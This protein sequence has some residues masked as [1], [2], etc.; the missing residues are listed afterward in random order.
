[1][2][3]DN[4]RYLIN[5]LAQSSDWI[6]AQ[7]IAV[8]M[9]V[10]TRSVRNYIKEINELYDQ[11]PIIS[12]PQGYKW[13]VNDSFKTTNNSN[14]TIQIAQTPEERWWFIIRKIVFL[15]TT[16]PTKQ[17]SIYDICNTLV[18]S[19]AV[20]FRDVDEIRKQLSS[21]NISLHIKND[22]LFISGAELDIRHL[23][24]DT[25]LYYSPNDILYR[26]YIQSSF[27]QYK[28][29]DL[30]HVLNKTLDQ[31]D[32]KCDGFHLNHFM[33]YIV[34]QIIR[35][36]NNHYINASEINIPNLEKTPEY[37]GAKNLADEISSLNKFNYNW[38]EIDY[39]AMLF[40]GLCQNHGQLPIE[41]ESTKLEVSQCLMHLC[42]REN[43]SPFDDE[44]VKRITDYFEKVKIRTNFHVT[45]KNPLR[46]SIRAASAVTHDEAS[47]IVSY[48]RKKWDIKPNSDEISYLTMLLNSYLREKRSHSTII[49]TTLICPDYYEVADFI[50]QHLEIHFGGQIRITKTIRSF[51]LDEI[52][53]NDMYISVVTLNDCPNYVHISPILTSKDYAM[54]RHEINRIERSLQYKKF[55]MFLQSYSNN[56]L[57]EI[58]HH[59]TSS[60]DAIEY[61]C[62]KLEEKE[63]VDSTFVDI[64][65]EREDTESTSYFNFIAVPHATVSSV[66]RNA[67]YVILNQKPCN[68]GNRKVKLIVLFAMTHESV[69]DYQHFYRTIIQLFEDKNNM[70]AVMEAYNYDQF[71]SIIN[72]L[73]RSLTK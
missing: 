18:I 47:W 23:F 48:F 37:L 41:Y 17:I 10:T 40:L 43:I 62:Q 67:I 19:E 52:E 34:V 15:N 32:L 42:K 55:S 63:I 7:Q 20:F 35:I 68:W 50:K 57:F 72:K 3:K 24:Y 21:Y 29:D 12:S 65:K 25:L 51:D 16:S 8:Q 53:P 5:V 66:K 22:H 11:N 4:I 14:S 38:W 49:N 31:Y 9:N 36:S 56:S 64:V 6:S 30:Y 73:Y 2:K 44:L 69:I 26:S 59:F 1:M 46:S 60:N 70:S 27:P 28:I 58:N 61:I 33:L 13:N 71:V 54:V 45:V 39:L